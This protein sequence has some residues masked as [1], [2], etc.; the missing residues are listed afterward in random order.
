MFQ[1]SAAAPSAFRIINFIHPSAESF[2][3]PLGWILI[4]VSI[5]LQWIAMNAQTSSLKTKT[6]LIPKTKTKTT[7]KPKT[8]K[9]V[10]IRKRRKRLKLLG[11]CPKISPHGKRLRRGWD[12]IKFPKY[13]TRIW[14]RKHAQNIPFL[15]VL[16]LRHKKTGLRPEITI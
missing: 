11:R 16:T 5:R 3:D 9:K 14:S 15:N 13:K 8:Q 7:L 10:I 1:P 2:L 4:S 6:H 12:F